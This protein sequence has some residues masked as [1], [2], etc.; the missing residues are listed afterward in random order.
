[1]SAMNVKIDKF[2]GR[3]SFSLWQIK[4]QALLKQQ[5][6]WVT[7]SKDNKG[8]GD[9][10][11]MAIMEEKAHS[12]I[13]LCL[14]D[15]VIIE[16]SGETTA[17]NMWKKLDTLYM[18]KSLQNKLLLKRRL[19]ALRMQEGTPLKDHLDQLN[20]VLLEL[21]IDVKVEDED[22]ALLLLVSLPLSYENFVESFIVN[23]VIVTLEEVRSALHR[24]LLRHQAAGTGTD[25][26]GSGLVASGSNGLGYNKKNRNR[27]QFSKGPKPDDVCNYC[28]ERGHWKSDCPKRKQPGS[29]AV[30]ENGTKSEQD[31][32]L[33]VSVNVQHSDVWVL[34][35]G[36]SYHMCPR[37]EWFSTYAQVE[38][39]C[40]KMA[41]SSISQVAGIGSI[42][43]RTHDGRFCTLNDVRHVPSMEKNLISLSLLDSS[44]L[45]YSG[46]DGV[47]QL[48]GCLVMTGVFGSG[49]DDGRARVPREDGLGYPVR[50]GSGTQRGRT[51]VPRED[52]LGY[53]EMTGR[54]P[55]LA[56]RVPKLA[57]S[58]PELD[59]RVPELAGSVSELAGRVPELAGSV[60]E[61][62]G[63]VSELAGS[64]PELGGSVTE[65]AGRLPELAGGLSRA[66]W[67]GPS[68]LFMFR[69]VLVCRGADRRRTRCEA[70][71]NAEL[72]AALES[73]KRIEDEKVEV[74]KLKEEFGDAEAEY[75]RLGA[76]LFEDL[77]I[78]LVSPDSACDDLE[79][80]SLEGD[81]NLTSEAA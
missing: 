1:M 10:A 50:T 14:E 8:K 32:A 48:G 77:K 43:I 44:G 51:R 11:E 55:E 81:A 16:V 61:L 28:K 78:P 2:S 27:N 25:N 76:E 62:A 20:S 36:A 74:L 9:A 21:R 68:R 72:I 67:K 29:A 39:G 56:G 73:G 3:N 6:L 41:N 80:R 19:F 35:T 54:V 63:R 23:K 7:L 37:R 57:G 47:L 46:G 4:M 60:S 79:N 42:H 58:V 5:G 12:T 49:Q 30:A 33:V 64:V 45:K 13:M 17:A 65:L 31:F 40:I 38:N 15:E 24:R 66:D 59:G 22:A 70:K 34:D 75:V 26:Q 18:T 71:A 52:G 53:Q 69:A